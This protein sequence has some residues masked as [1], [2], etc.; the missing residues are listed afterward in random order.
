MTSINLIWKNGPKIIL[1]ETLIERRNNLTYIIHLELMN[2]RIYVEKY[3]D[4]LL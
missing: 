4:M 3:S 1:Y 2:V